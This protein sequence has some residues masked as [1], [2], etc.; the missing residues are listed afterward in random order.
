MNV[1]AAAMLRVCRSVR[2]PPD[3]IKTILAS[4]QLACLALLLTASL[5][6]M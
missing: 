5:K 2:S 4:V 6:T 1:G 3:M